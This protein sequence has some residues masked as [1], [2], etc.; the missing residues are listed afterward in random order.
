MLTFLVLSTL[1]SYQVN[2]SLYNS[3]NCSTPFLDYN[4]LLHCQ[5]EYN[6]TNCCQDEYEKYNMTFGNQKCQRFEI[7]DTYMNFDCS[8]HTHGSEPRFS[9]QFYEGVIAG[10]AIL[11]VLIMFFLF[12]RCICCPRQSYARVP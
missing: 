1:S 9:K 3:S 7:N 6:V 10:G 5:E 12:M 8:N 4:Y 11:V 2:I